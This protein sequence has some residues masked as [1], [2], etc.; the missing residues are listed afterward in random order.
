MLEVVKLGIK[1]RRG[2]M[3]KCRCYINAKYYSKVVSS[4]SGG[5]LRGYKPCPIHENEHFC[6][7]CGQAWIVHD[8]DGSCIED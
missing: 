3:D 1:A 4:K 5:T 7:K 8:S 6:P 2:G